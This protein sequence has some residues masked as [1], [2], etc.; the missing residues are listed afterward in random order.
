MLQTA[1][2]PG[3]GSRFI[4]AGSTARLPRLIIKAD[5]KQVMLQL[6]VPLQ[7]GEGGKQ[8]VLNNTFSAQLGVRSEKMFAVIQ[9]MIVWIETHLCSPLSVKEISRKSGYSVWHLQRTFSQLTG[10]SVY[11]FVRTRRVINVI[12]ALIYGNK[13]LLDIA[14]ENGFNCQVSL[15][16][17]IKEFTGYTPGYIRRNF[18]MN[19]IWLMENLERLISRK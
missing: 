3:A 11:E 13:P 6:H 16:R 15:T 2:S 7:K 5:D 18:I 17:T 9:E 12:F 19:E 8:V 1:Y 14:L 4:P 10:F